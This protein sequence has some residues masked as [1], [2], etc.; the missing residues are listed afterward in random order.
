MAGEYR[1]G[2]LERLARMMNQLNKGVG[3]RGAFQR[4]FIE[5]DRFVR[6]DPNLPSAPES[7]LRELQADMERQEGYVPTPR[8]KHTPKPVRWQ[9]FTFD[10]VRVD[11]TPDANR[12]TYWFDKWANDP[13]GT[14]GYGTR[15][16]PQRIF[17][18]ILAENGMRREDFDW[19]LFRERYFRLYR[20]QYPLYQAH[21]RERKANG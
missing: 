21:E 3:K 10:T 2:H 13:T 5:G 6:L 20:E 14:E 1:K 11:E 12:L 9:D 8:K 19:R 4:V 16:T 7:Y 18:A 17:F 15:V